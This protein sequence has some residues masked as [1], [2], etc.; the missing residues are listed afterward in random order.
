MLIDVH[1]LLKDRLNFCWIWLMLF[2]LYMLAFTGSKA[3]HASSQ[4]P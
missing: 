1:G 4:S 3:S 2:M